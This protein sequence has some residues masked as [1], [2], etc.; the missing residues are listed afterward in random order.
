MISDGFVNWAREERGS[1]GNRR[2]YFT[3]REGSL[4]VPVA[5]VQAVEVVEVIIHTFK[6]MD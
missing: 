1:Y 2:L 3:M 4:E 6:Q 5:E